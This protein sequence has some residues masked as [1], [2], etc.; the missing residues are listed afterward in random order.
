MIVFAE[1][2]QTPPLMFAGKLKYIKDEPVKIN[3]TSYSAFPATN[4][5]WFIND[6]KVSEKNYIIKHIYDTLA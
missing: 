5:T 2:P 1:E 6:K 3:C 4:L